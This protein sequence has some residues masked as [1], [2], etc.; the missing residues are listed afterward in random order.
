[1]NKTNLL[2]SILKNTN[3]ISATVE[4][5]AEDV[6]MSTEQVKH[7]IQ[8]YYKNKFVNWKKNEISLTTNMRVKLAISA[9]NKGADIEKVCKVLEWQ[10]FE[11]FTATIFERNNFSVKRNFRFKTKKRKWEIDILAYNKPIIV[12]VDCKRWRRNWGNSAIKRI[13]IEQSKRTKALTDTLYFLQQKIGLYNW[14][15]VTVF[16][17]VMSLFP[18]GV[19]IYNKIPVVP[20]LQIQNFLDEFQ[21]HI[22]ELIHFNTKLGPKLS[23][24]NNQ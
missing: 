21:A 10:E 2:I 7:I 18:G 11:N 13:A 1:M 14:N 5:I 20:I 4:K 12:S 22:S 17:A 15:K 3:N 6:N 8:N 24:F 23:E 19:K 9:I 16:P